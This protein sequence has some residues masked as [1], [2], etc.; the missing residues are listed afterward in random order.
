MLALIPILPSAW[1]RRGAAGASCWAAPQGVQRG[2]F[3]SLAQ[4]L[5][6]ERFRRLWGVQASSWMHRASGEQ[7]IMPLVVFL[8][9]LAFELHLP[10]SLPSSHRPELLLPWPRASAG[11]GNW[12]LLVSTW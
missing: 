5:G 2:A 7:T 6:L 1:A 10:R 11:A 8:A 12:G 3:S 4:A 9:A